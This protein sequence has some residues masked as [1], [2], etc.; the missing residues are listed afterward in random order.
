M[1]THNKSTVNELHLTL[2][3]KN[4]AIQW[5]HLWQTWLGITEIIMKNK[6]LYQC[7]F[8]FKAK[9]NNQSKIFHW[10]HLCSTLFTA[11][12]MFEDEIE[13]RPRNI[14]NSLTLLSKIWVEK[15]CFC[16]W[17]DRLGIFPFG[18]SMLWI[19]ISAAKLLMWTRKYTPGFMQAQKCTS[20]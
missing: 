5:L 19:V 12:S 17:N 15:V 6:W 20:S 9:I 16:I 4:V 11:I 18:H 13:P 8:T 3:L 2:N 7:V 10:W 1:T 14:N